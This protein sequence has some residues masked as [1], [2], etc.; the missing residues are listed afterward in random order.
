AENETSRAPNGSAMSHRFRR[1]VTR[2]HSA[3][4]IPEITKMTAIDS[5][6]VC[7]IVSISANDLGNCIAPPPPP[8]PP[9]PSLGGLRIGAPV[10]GFDPGRHE[11]RGVPHEQERRG[12]AYELYDRDPAPQGA[13]GRRHRAPSDGHRIAPLRCQAVRSASIRRT[14]SVTAWTL[15]VAPEILRISFPTRSE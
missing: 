5:R 10:A 15:I 9:P 6:C 7:V 4:P 1:S 11:P 8:P 2:S 3:M 13:G 14:A 12:I